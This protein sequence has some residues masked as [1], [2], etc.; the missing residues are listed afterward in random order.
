MKRLLLAPLI[1]ALSLS[2]QADTTTLSFSRIDLEK[3]WQ[4]IITSS[5]N[6]NHNRWEK[7]LDLHPRGHSP[8][9]ENL[10]VILQ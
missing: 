2:A 10:K 4:N 1:L 3:P 6:K 9:N 7:Y 8:L 5:L